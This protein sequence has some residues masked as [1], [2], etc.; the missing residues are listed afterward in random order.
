MDDEP[1]SFFVYLVAALQKVKSNLGQEIEGVIHSGQLPPN[2]IV[3]AILINDLSAC[4]DRFLLVLDDFH[5][6]QDHFILQVLEQLIANLPDALHLVLVTREDPPLPLARLRANNQLTEIRARDLC[7]T[8]QD[9]DLFLNEVMGISLSQA[10]IAVLADK[11][12]G[13]IAGVQLAGLSIQDRP[14]PSGFIANLSGSHR[15]ILSYLTEQVLDQQPDEVQQ[16]LLETS[17][18][19][20]LN[21]DLCNAVTGRSDSASLLEHLFKANLFLIPLDDEGQ[22]Y[23]YHHLFSDLLRDRQITRL[24]DEMTEL[25]RRACHWY[26]QTGGERGSFVSEAIQHAL[27]AKDYAKAVEL[28]EHHAMGLTMQGYARTVNAWIRVLP[29]EWASQSPRTNLAF[30]WALMLRGAYP[31][32]IEYLER[33]KTTLIDSSLGA[34]N[35]AVQAEWL[36]MQ[37]LVLYMQGKTAQC[38]ELAARVLELAP[39]QD[40]RVRS[41]AY[42]VQASIY[43]LKEEYPQAVEIFRKAIHYSRAAENLVAEMLSTTS[44]SGMALE[45]GQL[46]LAY[47]I[48]SESVDRIER[49]GRLYPISAVIYA[50]LGDAYYQWFRVEEARHSFQHALHLSTLGGSNTISILCHVLL[51]RLNQMEGDLDAASREV[52]M[53]VDLLPLELPEYVRQSVAA[54][55]VHIYLALDRP[56]AAEI[57]LQAIGYSFGDQ[58]SFSSDSAG[59][60]AA[61]ISQARISSSM[62]GLYNSVLRFYLYRARSGNDS[63]GLT[64]ALELAD[65]VISASFRSQQ[66][67]I[68]LESLLLRAQ[69]HTLRGDH[70]ASTAD[71]V[72]ALSLAEPEGFIGIFIEQ[73]PSGAKA[74]ADLARRSKL[75]GISFDYIERILKAYSKFS[76]P[77]A[78]PPIT[79][80]PANG[81]QAALI[82]PLT[83][84]ELDVLRLMAEGLKYKEIAERLYISLNTVRYHVKAI[85]GKLNTSNR[86]YAIELARKIRIL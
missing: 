58:I 51:S 3:S 38:M 46:H 31:Q 17:I 45:H 29:E 57:A 74:L 53:A 69:M 68:A 27:A 28:L 40:S 35:T 60:T 21:G 13:W 12:E 75:E 82:E 42:Y 26:A 85:Y 70:R 24:K 10:D 78:Q 81:E 15:H 64:D 34:E 36:V 48:A 86:I 44:L 23:R 52:Q 73:G 9:I 54:Q 49:S 65:Q 79:N 55:Q 59:G 18:L 47:E 80:S 43:Q 76:L 83:D 16:F 8:R 72:K 37:S 19:D 22:W 41:L 6:I 1:E 33:L 77:G 71:Y 7:F 66:F 84:R 62:G 50:S 5:V 30:A 39:E 20:K 56:A 4:E 11:T 67:T 14:D 2:E 63:S 25:H 32:A 61:D